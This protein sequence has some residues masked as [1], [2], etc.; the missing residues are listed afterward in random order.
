MNIAKLAMLILS[1][2]AVSCSKS[3]SP[4]VQAEDAAFRRAIALVEALNEKLDIEH[5]IT[6]ASWGGASGD[7]KVVVVVEV[8]D[9]KSDY[10]ASLQ[11]IIDAIGPVDEPV[12]ISYE[13]S[14][15][16]TSE[17]V[18]SGMANNIQHLYEHT[19]NPAPEAPKE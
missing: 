5:A 10:K 3:P 9:P 14:M 19:L 15:P 13:W 7:D 11:T 8:E 4:E 1:L 12:V 6:A 2:F 17:Q 16:L 18:E